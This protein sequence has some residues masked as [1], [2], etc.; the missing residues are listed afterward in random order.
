MKKYVLLIWIAI[1][2]INANSQ[3]YHKLIRTNKFWDVY[4]LGWYD[5]N[6]IDKIFFTGNDTIIEGNAYQLSRQYPYEPV[7]PGYLIP[8]FFID[9]NSIKTNEFLREDTVMK[10]VYIYDPYLTP[11][12]QLLYDFSLSIGDTLKSDY[13][14]GKFGDYLVLTSIDSVT[15][16][17]GE[18]RK[19]FIFNPNSSDYGYYIEGIGGSQ[20]LF[21]PIVPAF[22]QN[23]QLG[24]F[25]ISQDGI[26]LLGDQC[27]WYFVGIKDLMEDKMVTIF[28]NP[29]TA[30]K[31]VI[32]SSNPSEQ[33]N[34][35]TLISPLSIVV[36][37]FSFKVTN[38]AEIDLHGII[39]G[40]YFLKILYRDGST[41][42]KNL[43]IQ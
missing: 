16:L 43:I 19:R 24:Y 25:C 32:S 27:N 10:K 38:N 26:N 14:K 30:G 13:N 39:P 35:I 22:E 20:G 40:S 7:N 6:A 34:L 21:P 1:M 33:F 4:S 37:K 42:Y 41:Q 3:N 11:T 28:P 15:L 31:L 29:C 9:T 17:N 23:E 12:D 5:Y 36:K 8:P 18:I 2:A